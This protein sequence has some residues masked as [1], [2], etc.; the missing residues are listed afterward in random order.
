MS[1]PIQIDVEAILASKAGDKARF[2]PRFL[3]S[4]LKK[5]IHQDE[6][7]GFLKLYGDK[8]DYDFVDAFMKFFKNSFEVHGL[9]NLPKDGRRLTFE[10]K[11]WDEK[12]TIGEGRHVRFVVDR[13]RFLSKL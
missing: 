9:E 12:G 7:N 2:V 13:E 11:A 6:V 8:M 5:I 1:K 3:I 4:Y 10:V